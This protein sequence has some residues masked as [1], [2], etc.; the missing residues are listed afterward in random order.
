M[1]KSVVS[2]VRRT[3]I[4]VRENVDS[5]TNHNFEKQLVNAVAFVISLSEEHVTAKGRRVINVNDVTDEERLQ[6][7]S[8]LKFLSEKLT[9]KL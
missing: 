1:K 8:V 3:V 4:E 6:A 7:L 5:L 9:I 2:D